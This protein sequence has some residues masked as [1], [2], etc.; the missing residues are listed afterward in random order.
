MYDETL[1]RCPHCG[2]EPGGEAQELF[3]LKPGTMLRQRYSVGRVLGF[4]GFGI[5]YKAL[6]TVT[7][8]IVAI[9]EFYPSG[10]VN[11][12]PGEGEV[13]LFARNRAAEYEE[14]M[15]RFVA[16]ASTLERYQG[17]DNIVYVM[18]HFAENGTVYMVLEYLDRSLD[19]IIASDGIMDWRAGLD[20]IRAVGNALKA[21]HADGVLHRD[22]GP[23]NIMISSY[24]E[25]KLID[26]GAARFGKGDRESSATRIMKPGYSPPEQYEEGTAQGEWTDIYAL[27]ATLYYAITGIKP[28]EATNRKITDALATP[29]ALNPEIPDFV[30]NAILKAMAV[31][32]HLRFRSVAEFEDALREDSKVLPPAAEAKK[33]K[34]KRAVTA[35]AAACVVLIGAGIFMLNLGRQRDEETLPDATVFLWYAVTGDE[36]AD[37]GKA[38]ALGAITD[39]F[40]EAF[41]NVTVT[42]RAVNAGEYGAEIRR[43][44]DGSGSPII[45]ESGSV[46][47]D[48]LDNAIELS[49]AVGSEQRDDC[50]FLSRY[51]R[52]FPD[53]KRLPLGFNAP[54]VYA[55]TLIA[56][57]EGSAVDDLSSL[58]ASMPADTSGIAVSAEKLGEFEASF[59][60]GLT[61]AAPESFFSEEVGAYFADT[62]EFFDVQS[63]L[64]ARYKLLR[65]EK[66]S[67]AAS[68]DGY[69]SIAKCGKDEQKA[70]ERLLAYM[71]SDMAQ[72]YLHVR[73]HSGALPINRRVLETF[74]QVYTDFDGVFGEEKDGVF[75]EI[76]GYAADNG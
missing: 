67:K 13:K 63:A 76:D 75:A 61:T 12:I 59:G 4:G 2:F 1:G 19:K 22:V 37:G 57:Y 49:A 56:S 11:R 10:L 7:N 3:Y 14:S 8:Y 21:V 29:R 30:N 9:K 55:N 24:G 25:V 41:P 17:Q 69:W 62:S 15:E 32:V 20:M 26:F 40:T 66:D 73:R 74:C 38:E 18:E 58:L 33:K 16:E 68:F 35:I 39:A 72:D 60:S 48:V 5:I 6:D 31:N 53:K 23:D 46:D 70:A 44:V 43:A 36:E 42:L 65:I 45:F 71:L 27:G 54:V 64:P 51:S 52:L 50:Y 34:K 28:E 47:D